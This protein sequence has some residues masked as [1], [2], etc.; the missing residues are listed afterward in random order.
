[1]TG[2]G[3]L[4]RDRLRVQD[5]ASGRDLIKER[6]RDMDRLRDPGRD[7]LYLGT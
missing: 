2:A 4:D 1:M 6:D 5:P 3:D 7:R